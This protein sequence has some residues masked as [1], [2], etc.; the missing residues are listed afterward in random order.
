M[1]ITSTIDNLGCIF[2][3]GL[4][5]VQVLQVV[6]KLIFTYYEKSFVSLVSLLRFTGLSD[7]G[8]GITIEN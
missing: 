6:L 5:Y 4:M 1:S 7:V 2:L 3:D 8:R